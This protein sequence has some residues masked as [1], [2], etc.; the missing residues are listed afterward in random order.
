MP[1]RYG[2]LPLRHVKRFTLETHHAAENHVGDVVI[3]PAVVDEDSEVVIRG[4]G[5]RVQA[6]R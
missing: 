4:G 6:V 2:H 3:V 5:R 1:Q